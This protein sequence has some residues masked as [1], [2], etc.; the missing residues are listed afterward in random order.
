VKAYQGKTGHLRG[1]NPFDSTEEM[2][3]AFLASL[4]PVQE[5]GML[6][7]MLFQYPPWFECSKPNVDLLRYAKAKMGGLP[8]WRIRN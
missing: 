6:R 1:E 7:A 3:D 4:R 5:A 8:G 2:F